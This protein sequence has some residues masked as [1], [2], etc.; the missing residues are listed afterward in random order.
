MEMLG[1]HSEGGSC[2]EVSGRGSPQAVGGSG[3]RGAGPQRELS[4]WGPGENHRAQW[5]PKVPT[6]A[7]R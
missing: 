7:W 4:V 6:G 1:G 5:F 2:E 3:G